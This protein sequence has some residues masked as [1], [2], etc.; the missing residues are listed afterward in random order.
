AALRRHD[1]VI[2]VSA[3]LADELAAR[4]VRR[5]RLV[6]VRNAWRPPGELPSREAA[7]ALL[8]IPA[9]E[10]VAGWV[11]RLAWVK[12]PELAL[13][14]LAAMGRDDVRLSFVG[15]GPDRAALEAAAR[16]LGLAGR[17]RFHGM[18]A[19][20]W[21]TLPAFDA[22]LLSSRSEGT[23]MVLLEAM[24]AGVPIVATAVGGVP[25]LLGDAAARLV[26]PGDAAAL[27]AAL[28][29]TLDDARGAQARVQVARARL[30]NDFSPDEWIARHVDLYRRL[31]ART[32]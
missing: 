3:P 22:L 7:R 10:R 17:V 21:R 13:A 5:D 8:G 27:G 2:A 12:A 29:D 15:D 11:G 6:L 32:R 23:P 19:E 18:L 30:Q 24:H 16:S 4:G 25:D 14:A 1:A 9:G 26:P 20:A 28:A 31:V